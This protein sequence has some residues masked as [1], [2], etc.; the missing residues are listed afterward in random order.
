MNFIPAVALF[1]LVSVAATGTLSAE[2]SGRAPLVVE[3]FTSQGCDACPPADRLIGEV[4]AKPGI[5]ALTYNVDYWDY[6]GWSDTFANSTSTDRQRAYARASRRIELSTPQIIL[7]GDRKLMGPSAQE[8]DFA[9]EQVG[10]SGDPKLEV[11]AERKNGRLVISLPEA[12]LDAE[13]T[14]WLV[15]FAHTRTQKVERGDNAGRLLT[16]FNVVHDIANLGLWFG[17]RR[18]IEFNEEQLADQGSDGCALLIQERGY[19][20]I[21]GAHLMNFPGRSAATR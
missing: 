10:R 1:A 13:T 4:G 20:R 2:P 7:D 8:L 18:K 21:L 15:R 9:L 19:G 11:T 14:I 12:T 3:L 16:Y 17:E 6:I 5:I